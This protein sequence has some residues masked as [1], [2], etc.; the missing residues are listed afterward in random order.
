MLKYGHYGRT[1]YRIGHALLLRV[2]IREGSAEIGQLGQR[3]AC[4]AA[5]PERAP[6]FPNQG[7]LLSKA[8]RTTPLSRLSP[9]LRGFLPLQSNLSGHNYRLKQQTAADQSLVVRM[10]LQAYHVTAAAILSTG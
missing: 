7:T 2:G 1:Y 8:A 4:P 6:F 10:K 9:S 3:D 5:G